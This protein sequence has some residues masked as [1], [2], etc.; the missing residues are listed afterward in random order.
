MRKDFL[1]FQTYVRCI[2]MSSISYS[3]AT[4]EILT[5]LIEL[6]LN[7]GAEIEDVRLFNVIIRNDSLDSNCSLNSDCAGIATFRVTGS[8]RSISR[9][10]D[11]FSSWRILMYN[12]YSHRSGTR[13]CQDSEERTCSSRRWRSSGSAFFSRSSAWHTSSHPT[14]W[15]VRP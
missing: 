7:S 4:L 2:I 14:A 12:S 11:V 5:G 3:I 1:Q 10:L 9:Y 6:Q 13:V 8:C 15:S